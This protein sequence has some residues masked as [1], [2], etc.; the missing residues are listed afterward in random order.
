MP[1]AWLPFRK[2][3]VTANGKE[4][5]IQ[6]HGRTDGLGSEVKAGVWDGEDHLFDVVA[7]AATTLD[8]KGKASSAAGMRLLE[9]AK[10]RAEA[11]AQARLTNGRWVRGGS[12]PP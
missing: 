11:T 10:S 2:T 6:L 5:Q 7:R 1:G 9:A 3:T 8:A 4:F 12:Y